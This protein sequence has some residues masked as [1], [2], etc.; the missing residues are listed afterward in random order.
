MEA[1][2]LTAMPV[3]TIVCSALAAL[4]FAAAPAAA[5]DPLATPTPT[6]TATP[7]PEQRIRPGV[8][9]GGVDLS[10]KTI[11]EARA[12]LDTALTA[13]LRSPV[14]V[15]VAGH[16]YTLRMGTIG[17]KF[18]ALRTAKRAY[19]AGENNPPTPDSAGGA[20]AKLDVPLAVTFRKAKIREFAGKL[21]RELYVAPCDATLRITLRKMI[22]RKSA[23]GRDLDARALR[24]AIEL[25]V[26]DAAAAREIRPGRKIV[27][28]KINA[29]DLEKVYPTVLTVDRTNFKL[30]VFKNLR[31]SKTYGVAVG[32]AGYDTPTGRYRIQ[33]K[34]VNPAWTAPNKPWAGLYAGRTVAGGAPDNPL[35]ARWLGIANGVG[36]HGTGSEYSIGSRASHG[37]IRMRVADVI[38]L[39]PRVPVGTPVLI[40]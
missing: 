27:P 26:G 29:L 18:D 17:F 19:Y 34:S 25:T 11:E 20:G 33:N 2:T 37:C 40:Q 5:Q 14:V 1:N 22:R 12:A 30:R 24:S 4:A 6:P 16:T 15:K 38:D 36:I 3:R 35:K 21:D 9:A 23:T 39:Y 10:N 28:A 31:L 8:R 32:A 13:H 7:A